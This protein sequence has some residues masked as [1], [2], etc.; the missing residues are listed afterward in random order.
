MTLVIVCAGDSHLNGALCQATHSRS[1]HKANAM[2]GTQMACI[3]NQVI[4]MVQMTA[5]QR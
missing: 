3:W 2:Y 1:W 5:A 4:L